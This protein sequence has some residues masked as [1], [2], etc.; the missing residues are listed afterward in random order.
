GN[1]RG[2]ARRTHGGQQMSRPTAS[3]ILHLIRRT[4]AERG[5]AGCRDEELLER[6]LAGNDE[7]AF[8]AILCRHGPMV[9]G[10]CRALLGSDAD[11][12]NASEPAFPTGARRAGR[13][14]G[15][16]SRGGWLHGVASRPAL[17]ARA[18]FAR[19]R[20]H[21]ARAAPREATAPEDPSWTEVREAL[22]EELG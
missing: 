17:K 3:P 20:K 4:L 12:G 8:E 14:R 1:N 10:L 9:L 13:A 6:F 16:G 22:H 21:E 7:S 5:A 19:R 11:A 15:G 2:K 18:G